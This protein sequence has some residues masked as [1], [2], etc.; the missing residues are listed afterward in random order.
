MDGSSPRLVASPV[1][2]PALMDERRP[3]LPNHETSNGPGAYG[4]SAPARAAS[5]LG[6][7]ARQRTTTQQSNSGAAA[8]AASEQ[9]RSGRSTPVF[10][11]TPLRKV[12]YLLPNNL[13]SKS[14]QYWS[15]YVPVFSW[16]PSYS[17]RLFA[18]DI[19]AGLTVRTRRRASECGAELETCL[20]TLLIV[21]LLPSAIVSSHTT[22]DVI[23]VRAR[24]TGSCQWWVSLS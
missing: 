22:V 1:S 2:S 3:L 7:D 5:P 23:R 24:K 6:S 9:H 19:A 15:Y 4:T 16:L 13:A 17:F 8:P 10:M 20:F 12:S 14:K 18:G 21:R 11:P